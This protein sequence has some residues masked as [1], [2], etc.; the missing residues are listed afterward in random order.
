M[1]KFKF[2]LY[3][4]LVFVGLSFAVKGLCHERVLL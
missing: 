1:G 2:C 4:T 3:N